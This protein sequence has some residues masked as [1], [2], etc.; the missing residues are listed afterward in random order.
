MAL[1][2]SFLLFQWNSSCSHLVK[3][4]QTFKRGMYS[5]EISFFVESFFVLNAA[6][7]PSARQMTHDFDLLELKRPDVSSLTPSAAMRVPACC[8]CPPVT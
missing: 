8:A 6:T 4:N 5:I 7:S 2:F 3:T 1:L